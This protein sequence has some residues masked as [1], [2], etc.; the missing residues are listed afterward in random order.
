MKVGICHACAHMDY[1]NVVFESGL[2]R[3]GRTLLNL[4]VDARRSDRNRMA[5]WANRRRV[6]ADAC[7]MKES[8]NGVPV[9]LRNARTHCL[10]DP[11]RSMLRR[12]APILQYGRL[13]GIS[14]H[15]S[16]MVGR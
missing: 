10:G 13:G 7:S 3:N 1:G 4:H 12:L 16:R 15:C 11:Y 2:P 6:N 5:G 14:D 8:P 9:C